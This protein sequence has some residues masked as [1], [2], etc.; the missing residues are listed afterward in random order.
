MADF[1]HRRDR[2]LVRFSG[3]LTLEAAVDLVET[4]DT[5]VRVYFYDLIEIQISS[6]GGA[7]SALEHYLDAH[8]RW[9]AAGVRVRTC[10]ISRAASAAALIL[11]LGD[12]RIAEPGASL[13]YHLFRMPSSD[14]VTASAAA[15]IFADL[16][17][18]DEQYVARL[19][20]RAMA[21][22]DGAAMV[23]VEVEPSD[24][25]VLRLLTADL[26]SGVKGRRRTLRGL[27]RALERAVRRA[28][29]ANDRAAL[30]EIYRKLC[31]SELS[32]SPAVARLLRLIDRVGTAQAPSSVAPQAPGLTIPQW[33]ALYPPAGE[34]PRAILTRHT[35]ALGD[36]GSGKSASAVLPVV[37][38]LVHAPAGRVGAAL[39]I[40]PKGEIGPL[41]EREAPERLHT[42]VPSQSGLDLMAG[43]DWSLA[44]H[45]TAGHFLGAAMRIAVRVLGFDPTL[46][47]RV[48]VEH[49]APESSTHADYFDR[50]GSALLLTTL[51]FVLM[52]TR[53][54]APPPAQWCPDDA[55]E[56]MQRLL[57]RAQGGAG[58]RGHNA[59]ALAAYVLDTGFP[60]GSASDFPDHGADPPWL[61][62]IAVGGA[63][64]QWGTEPGEA[65][66]L[67]D[68]V[69]G[70]WQPMAREVPRQFAGVL[71]SARVACSAL[72]EPGLA[73][74]IYFGCEPGAAG[75][76]GFARELARVVSRDAPGRVL[77]YQPSRS[78]LDSLV[79]KALKAL[80]FEAVLNDPDRVRGGA[81]LPLVGYVADECHRFI[82]S[83]PVHGEQGFLDT[84]RSFGVA[85]VFAC[86][87]I[88]S[89]EHAL[90]QRGG[91]DAQD[92]A[93]VSILWNNTG[94][95]LFFRST[96]PRTA[97]RVDDVCPVL[98]GLTP[99]TRVRPLPSLVPGECYAV[100]ADGRF[101]RRQLEPVL[102]AAPER[103][104]ARR[105]SRRARPS[106]GTRVRPGSES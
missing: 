62:G 95:K 1:Q 64:S 16:T 39:V 28:L 9:R 77:L 93:A 68:R 76:G 102:P 18:L 27:A 70:Y 42:V 21:D 73:T 103:S 3:E 69:K 51:A 92:R 89:I 59:L 8:R 20:D 11:S 74:V 49:Q 106:R 99:V 41:L 32:V 31:R 17:R 90:A 30:V 14:P 12:E 46:P 55:R 65:R 15:L 60:L 85:C 40:D 23:S 86:Q 29:R 80:F 43:P 45:L 87:S 81:D 82:T 35:L 97:G 54:G 36:T 56:W 5:L 52:V 96:D 10:V 105:P 78:G 19:V 98:P 101:E 38:A 57:A 72:A 75:T 94:S 84:C 13:L 100:L 79:G 6:L 71:S 24:S 34:V 37:R 63:A 22:A 83:D 88:A 61:F 47:T 66:D 4:I 104:A 33:A 91:G 44:D 48:L 50:D 26:P 25:H 2:A 67:V 7:S 58:G 53:P